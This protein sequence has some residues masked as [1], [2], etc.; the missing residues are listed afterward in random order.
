MNENELQLFIDNG[1]NALDPHENDLTD[2]QYFGLINP[3]LLLS[4][5]IFD[6]KKDVYSLNRG[7]TPEQQKAEDEEK[8]KGRQAKQML[9][10]VSN[11]Q[12][13]TYT[14]NGSSWVLEN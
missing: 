4:A 1:R 2:R 12:E 10:N 3:S 13:G 7:L 14:W 11:L 9:N 8:E 5:N 6:I